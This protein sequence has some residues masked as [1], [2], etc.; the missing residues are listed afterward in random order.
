[1][2]RIWTP[3]QGMR[4][5]R[6]REL[7]RDVRGRLARP[8]FFMGLRTTAGAPA[9]GPE[10]VTSMGD[11]FVEAVGTGTT[12]TTSPAPTGSNLYAFGA[13]AAIDS[14]TPVISGLSY[15]DDGTPVAMTRLLADQPFAFTNAAVAPFGV[16]GVPA[17]AMEFTGTWDVQRLMAYVN[18]AIFS[19]VHQTVPITGVKAAS[20]TGGGDVSNVMASITFTTADPGL[21][22][23]IA[24]G[25]VFAAAIAFST[26]SA[27]ASAFTEQ[28]GTTLCPNPAVFFSGGLAIVYGA[29]SGGTCTLTL[30][31][32]HTT[33]ADM[34]WVAVGGRLNPA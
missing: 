11:D 12:P 16:A 30:R 22:G 8:Q 1:M 24:D 18:A 5:I 29:A 33:P 21:E 10:F 4:E 9:A 32:D 31:C 23:G 3:E 28:A 2:K 25:A 14:G 15:D 19:G 13:V 20:G 7:V 26:N 17:E 34:T 27:S 6:A